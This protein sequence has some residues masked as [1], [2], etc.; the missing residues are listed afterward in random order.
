MAAPVGG[1]ARG[2]PLADARVI[3][4]ITAESTP[5]RDKAA[6]CATEVSKSDRRDSITAT[7]TDGDNPASVSVTMSALLSI[8]SAS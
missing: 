7:I 1:A 8:S 3:A 2:R 6:N 4:S 5:A